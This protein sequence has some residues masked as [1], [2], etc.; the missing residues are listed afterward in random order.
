MGAMNKSDVVDAVASQSGETSAATERVID[1]LF[2]V[3]GN[4]IGR[5]D[6][7]TI[8]GWV[9]FEQGFRAAREGR[10]PRT[11][12]TIQIAATKTAKLKAGSKLKDKAKGM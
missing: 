4:A 12:E 7:V 1:S 6:K 5:G 10:N 3:V 11:G 8:T 9:T 2:E